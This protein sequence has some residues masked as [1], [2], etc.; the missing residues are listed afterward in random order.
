MHT[1]N[2][3][4]PRALK[5]NFGKTEV[6][7]NAGVIVIDTIRWMRQRLTEKAESIFQQ[8][9]GGFL[10]DSKAVGDQG[11]FYLL[12]GTE[13]YGLHPKWNMRRAPKHSIQLLSDGETG[14]VHLA[15]TTHGD[16]GHLCEHSMQYPNF[17]PA[18]LPLYLA[19][20]RSFHEKHPNEQLKA[21]KSCL[22]AMDRL[23]K[24]QHGN[25]VRIKYNPGKGNFVF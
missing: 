6:F 23:K 12:L 21:L 19:I 18:V 4:L 24:A 14:I 15:G 13:A 7:L 10:F 16:A 3:E 22:E 9:T 1:I 11:V 20:I 25:A 5:L 8:N 17:F 2:E